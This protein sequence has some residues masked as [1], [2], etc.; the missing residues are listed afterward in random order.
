MPSNIGMD[1]CVMLIQWNTAEQNGA[2]YLPPTKGV[3]LTIVCGEQT[4][5]DTNESTVHNCVWATVLFLQRSKVGRIIY[6]FPSQ[7]MNFLGKEM[8]TGGGTRGVS[9]HC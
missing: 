3:N 7:H 8:A 6:T 1:Q 9:G 2:Q 4:K 5:P